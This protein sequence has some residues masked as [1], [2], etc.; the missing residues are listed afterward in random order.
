MVFKLLDVQKFISTNSFQKI[1]TGRTFIKVDNELVP[2][3]GSLYDPTIFGFTS[4]E[5]FEKFAYIDLKE[6]VLHPFIF[7]NII[8][9]GTHFNKCI[10]KKENYIIKDGM[11]FPDKSGG[12][13]INFIINNF[14]KFIFENYRHDKNKF[15]IDILTNTQKNMILINKIPVIPIGYRNYRMNRGMIEEDEITALYKKILN[16]MESK[17]WSKDLDQSEKTAFDEVLSSI[18]KDT[19]KKEYIQKYVYN[20]YDYFI[21][22]LEK[23]DGLIN[24]NLLGKRFNNVARFVINAQPTIPIDCCA[25]P[26][27]G[28][29][30]IFDQFVIA[31]LNKE[32]YSEISKE[33]GVKDRGVDEIGELLDYIYKNT[34]TYNKTYPN[35]EKLWIR[36]LEDIFNDNQNLRVF[37]KRDPGWSQ[38]SFWALKPIIITG[39]AY[40][41]IMP[42]FLYNPIGG[43]SFY[44]NFIL[45]IIEDT[46]IDKTEDFIITNNK[47]SKN[48]IINAHQLI[49][50]IDK[51]STS[52]SW[53]DFIIQG[54]IQKL[55]W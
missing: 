2:N 11:L 30:I 40:N 39:E 55:D 44:S 48:K 43:D 7:K 13:G 21:T 46:I 1:L 28:L 50:S 16:I 5:K 37:A 18:Y 3:R 31:Y 41:L 4:K 15:F 35:N 23:K 53:E 49:S 14:D 9:V 54:D 6:L 8:K 24:N 10:Q 20:L 32:E 34:S 29:L 47:G 38:F 25:V 51:D 42:S 17:E 26:W 36:I 45:S 19:S 27:Q 12:T 52:E 22:T 33:L